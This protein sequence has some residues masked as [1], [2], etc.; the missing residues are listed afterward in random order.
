LLSATSELMAKTSVRLRY[1]NGGHACELCARRFGD[2]GSGGGGLLVGFDGGSV[3]PNSYKGYLFRTPVELLLH[4]SRAHDDD[5]DDNNNV[6]EKDSARKQAEEVATSI[7]PSSTPAPS[8]TYLAT[9]IEEHVRAPAQGLLLT[10]GALK[11]RQ[12]CSSPVWKSQLLLASSSTMTATTSLS[13]ARLRLEA[14][15]NVEHVRT[16][17]RS[18]IQTCAPRPLLSTLQ[19]PARLSAQQAIAPKHATTRLVLRGGGVHAQT[20]VRAAAVEDPSGQWCSACGV[21]FKS[22]LDLCAHLAE[23]NPKL[24]L[25]TSAAPAACLVAVSPGKLCPCVECASTSS[26]GG[27]GD[28]SGGAAEGGITRAREKNAVCAGCHH[29]IMLHGDT[30]RGRPKAVVKDKHPFAFF[31]SF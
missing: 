31:G 29:P 18:N 23:T 24:C 16:S 2:G 25:A 22:V 12:P 28:S 5:D 7:S 6:K 3:S 20:A 26:G 15:S 1:A 14:N 30:V 27:G 4:V 11:T 19:P 13:D 21:E 9:L 10:N 17:Y 8:A